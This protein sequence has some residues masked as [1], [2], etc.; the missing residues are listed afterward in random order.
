[1]PRYF[2][3]C[4]RQTSGRRHIYTP[5]QSAEL[6]WLSLSPGLL[7]R[8]Q[9]QESRERKQIVHFQPCYTEHVRLFL[10][11]RTSTNIVNSSHRGISN[12]FNSL[13]VCCEK[14]DPQD[15]TRTPEKQSTHTSKTL[16]ALAGATSR[17]DTKACA[18]HNEGRAAA[19]SASKYLLAKP[20]SKGEMAA[21]DTKEG[22]ASS[23]SPNRRPVT[24][25]P[26]QKKT[27]YHAPISYL[28]AE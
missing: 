24:T 23:L 14:P 26:S 12:F 1:M 10:G 3:T 20:G 22:R 9:T 2:F 21:A 18:Y 16:F 17:P 4:A 19:K 13:F 28:K 11:G 6:P 5:S 7:K 15:R 8:N 25:T 27:C